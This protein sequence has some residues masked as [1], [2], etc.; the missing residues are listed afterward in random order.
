M[1]PILIKYA[2]TPVISDDRVPD[3]SRLTRC[4]SNPVDILHDVFT[5]WLEIGK[6]GNSVGDR[7]EVINSE[8]DADG[9]GHGDEMENSVGGTAKSHCEDL[10]SAMSI[11]VRLTMAFSKA[12]RVMMSRGRMFFSSSCLMVA[13][14]ESASASFSGYSAGKDDDPGRHI[15][16]ASIAEAMVLAVYI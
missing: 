5:T 11:G 6:E 14:T 10:T 3:Q 4:S 13:P 8:G 12:S 9:V 15:P 2:M 1:R 7:L 16:R